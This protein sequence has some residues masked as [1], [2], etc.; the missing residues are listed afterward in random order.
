KVL[1]D[2]GPSISCPANVTVSTDPFTCCATTD[3][4]DVIISDNCS[5]IN[6]ISGMIIGID[7]SNNDTI[8]MFPI[9]GNLTN[10]P[11]NN[12]W[13]PDTLGA[14]GLSPCLPQGTHTVV[15]Q[16]EDDCGNTT[17][18]TFRITV[19][20]FV[21]PVA[22]C[23]EHTIVSIGL[24]DPFDC[25]G[26]EGPGGQPAALGDCDGAGVTWV[27]AKTFDDG[28]YDNCNNIKFTIQ[29]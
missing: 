20:D 3:L 6:N 16:A 29:R 19:R 27:K 10:F 4:P 26:P 28:S 14:F 12:L 22:A 17:T 11:G 21:P 9:G 25:Y 24:D 18:C 7:P 13:N 15:Y 2:Q 23:D 5:R 8:G 1:D